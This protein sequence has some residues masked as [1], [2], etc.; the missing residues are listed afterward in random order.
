MWGNKNKTRKDRIMYWN[1]RVSKGSGRI[2][3]VGLNEENIVH[4]YWGYYSF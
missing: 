1:R 3:T 2:W 4:F